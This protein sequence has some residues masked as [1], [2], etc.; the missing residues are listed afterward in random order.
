MHGMIHE[1]DQIALRREANAADP[2]TA[3]IKHIPY[4]ILQT[5]MTIHVMN[6]CE[7]A[8]R[9]PVCPT[10]I[11]Q[12]LPGRASSQWRTGEHSVHGFKLPV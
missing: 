5:A 9:V 2:A 12:Y 6:N 10:N 11:G 8:V 4:R 3:L 1:C 7:L